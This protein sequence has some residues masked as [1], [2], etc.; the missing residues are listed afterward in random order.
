[1]GPPESTAFYPTSS[2]PG[3]R[4]GTGHAAPRELQR[5]LGLPHAT[6][7][8]VGT[9]IGASIFVQASEIAALVP[10]I[11]AVLLAWTICGFLT[12][13]GALACAELVSAYPRTGGVYVFLKESFGPVVGFLWGWSMFW[14]MHSGIIAVMA[15]VFARY[16]GFFVPLDA[17]GIRALAVAAIVVIS[18]INYFGVRVGGA[19]QT[20][21]TAGKLIAI[22]LLVS[23]GFIIGSRLTTHFQYS[24]SAPALAHHPV[25]TSGFLLALMAGLFTFG[26]WHIVTYTAEETVRPERTIPVAL[27]GGILIVT[28]SYV[29]LNAVYFYVLPLDQVIASSRVAADAATVLVGARGAAVISGLVTFSAFGAM[30]GSILAAPRVYFAM[31]RDGLLFRWVDHVHP[32]FRTP[33]RAILLQAVWAS[34]LVWSGTYRQLFTRVI[35]TEWIFFALMA[36]GIFVLRRRPDY[37]PSY[38]MWGY[39]WVPVVFMLAAAAIVVNRLASEPFD[40]AIGLALVGL[41]VPVF[42]AW[43]RWRP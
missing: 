38:R 10:N 11:P 1:M 43:C 33:D 24:A 19:L 28:A 30:S 8:V 4:P 37:R 25:S 22:S 16:A 23:V 42:H 36:G 17:R 40:S 2:G 15:V 39:P 5:S 20:A 32:R 6:S 21:F 34:A 31:A 29:A 27:V 35:F 13:F 3:Q 18:A 7:L 12:M 14:I 41:G 26:G 9:I